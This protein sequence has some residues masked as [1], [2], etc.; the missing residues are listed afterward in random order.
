MTK[1]P[2]SARD[3]LPP[4]NV[5]DE[6]ALS[7][8]MVKARSDAKSIEKKNPGHKWTSA[9]ARDSV[10]FAIKPNNAKSKTYAADTLKYF[11]YV[12]NLQFSQKHDYVVCYC[13]P[14]G[15]GWRWEVRLE[16]HKVY[17]VTE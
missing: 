13:A 6:R 2:I 5:D 14:N 8:Q 15:S 9:W 4:N 17:Y 11:A 3:I 1:M 7:I 16:S 12:T 10:P